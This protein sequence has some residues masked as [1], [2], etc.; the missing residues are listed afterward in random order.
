[1]PGIM[2]YHL[3]HG[4]MKTPDEAFPLLIRNLVPQGLRGFMFAAPLALDLN[5][6]LIPIRKPGKL[7]FQTIAHSY[8]LEYGSDTLQ[9]HSDAIP[10][11]AKVLV[12]DDLLAIGIIAVVGDGYNRF[13]PKDHHIAQKDFSKNLF[14][15]CCAYDDNFLTAAIKQRG[16]DQMMFGT[17]FPG[18]GGAV[19]SDFRYT[20]YDAG[21]NL[22]Q[23]DDLT[24]FGQY[25]P[26]STT[27]P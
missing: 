8:D 9:I 18:S 22:R 27:K 7:P 15:D 4:Q 24:S 11:G 16:V 17:E 1:M 6:G 19:R 26:P 10:A 25:T 2:S 21:G 5:V 23:L 20:T 3:Y 14:Y 13:I 12:V